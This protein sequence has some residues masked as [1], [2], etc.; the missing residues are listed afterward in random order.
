MPIEPTEYQAFIP[1]CPGSK[2]SLSLNGEERRVR[3][4]SH[5]EP[6]PLG[7]IYIPYQNNTRPFRGDSSAGLVSTTLDPYR[8]CPEAERGDGRSV[9]SGQFR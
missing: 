2:V 8:D 1:V 5:H 3:F 9:W 6:P 4:C 7:P